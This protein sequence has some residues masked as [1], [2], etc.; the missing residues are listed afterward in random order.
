M[1]EAFDYSVMSLQRVRIM[2]VK[3]KDIP[4]GKWRYLSDIEVATIMDM[5]KDSSKTN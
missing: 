3:L 2:N 4:L 1:C 5:V